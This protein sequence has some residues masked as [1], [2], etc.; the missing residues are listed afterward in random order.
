MF[1]SSRFVLPAI[2]LHSLDTPESLDEAQ[3][4]LQETNV[5]RRG[6]PTLDSSHFDDH[7][8]RTT[9]IFAISCLCSLLSPAPTLMFMLRNHRTPAGTPA[10]I[11][12]HSI[13]LVSSLGLMG[14]VLS[15][16][17]QRRRPEMRYEAP[18]LAAG[19]GIRAGAFSDI[20]RNDSIES[21]DSGMNHASREV[22]PTPRSETAN[23]FDY[24]GC[25]MLSFIF[26]GY[27]R[28]SRF[29]IGM[30]R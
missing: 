15:S 29:V 23:V 24:D 8:L 3:P 17:F 2:N 21:E 5:H 25:C 10:N 20:D 18:L 26:G 22:M 7:S 27:V 4:L 9:L 11:L 30:S 28:L 16:G 14:M 6:E 1:T 12:H 19:F 13:T